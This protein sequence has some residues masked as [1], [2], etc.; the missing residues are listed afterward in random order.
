MAVLGGLNLGRCCWRH[1]RLPVLG[2]FCVIYLQGGHTSTRSRQLDPRLWLAEAIVDM[3]VMGLCS[4]LAVA[5]TVI[6]V[7]SRS[8]GGAA[9]AA[10]AGGIL[11]GKAAASA[12]GSF[13]LIDEGSCGSSSA[14]ETVS[15]HR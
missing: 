1:R 13:C 11:P 5:L 2:I 15:S 3:C 9:A 4:G 6:D 8:F 14:S 7:T 12:V 10:A